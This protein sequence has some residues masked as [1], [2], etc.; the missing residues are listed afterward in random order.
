MFIFINININISV[1]KFNIA[2]EIITQKIIFSLVLL[3]F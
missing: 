1:N 2:Y 3:I